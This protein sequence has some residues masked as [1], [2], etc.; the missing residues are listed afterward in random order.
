MSIELLIDLLMTFDIIG[1]ILCGYPTVL[2]GT[3]DIKS[4]TSKNF[5][6][7]TSSSRMS[8][9]ALTSFCVFR[10][11]FINETNSRMRLFDALGS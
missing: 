1:Y 11:Q 8:L 9:I 3:G 4:C 7:G 5:R 6:M 10:F 2:K